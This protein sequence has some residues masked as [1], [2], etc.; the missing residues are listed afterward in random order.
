[1]AL[2]DFALD[3]QCR[4]F[5]LRGSERISAIAAKFVLRALALIPSSAKGSK[6]PSSPA[7]G[8]FQRYQVGVWYPSNPLPDG[9]GFF[10][11]GKLS[12][13]TLLNL[14][15]ASPLPAHAFAF[16]FT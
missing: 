3:A 7:P 11:S 4:L 12:C 14:N 15:V 8:D 9:P 2:F 13:L 16:P 5:L 10:V 1:M 6:R